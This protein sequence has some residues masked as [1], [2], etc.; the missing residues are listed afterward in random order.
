MDDGVEVAAEPAE[1]ESPAQEQQAA[2]LAPDR[3]LGASQEA[4][5]QGEPDQC[6]REH[7]F[8]ARESS[9]RDLYEEGQR[10]HE[11]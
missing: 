5:R 10:K 8:L 1:P 9:S 11:E 4:P 2:A 3:E 7:Y 6:A